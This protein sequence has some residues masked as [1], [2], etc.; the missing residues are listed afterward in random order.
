MIKKVKEAISEAG[1]R[2]Q[3]AIT[4]TGA[5]FLSGTIGTGAYKGLR[6]T[7]YLE[8]DGYEQQVRTHANT[9]EALLREQNITLD[10]HDTVE[11]SKATEITDGMEIE[12]QIARPVNITVDDD[13]QQVWST[14]D[15]VAELL[16]EQNITVTEHDLV[17]PAVDK[18]LEENM[19]IQIQKAFE[20][21]LNDGGADKQLWSTSA[22]VADFLKE[23]EIVVNDLDRVEPSQE[24]EIQSGETINVIR[25]EKVTDVVEEPIQYETTRKNDATLE[26]GQEQVVEAGENGV[27]KN[28]VE[29]TKENGKEVSRKRL[30]SEVAKE[31]T[32]RVIAVGTKQVVVEKTQPK[33]ASVR[34]SETAS[35]G[36]LGSIEGYTVVRKFT[37]ESTAYTPAESVNGGITAAGHNI[38]QN[39]NMRLIAVDPSVIP[40]GTRV[41]VE[42]YGIAIAGDTGGAIRGNKIDVLL[43]TVAEALQ[44]GRRNVT[45]KILK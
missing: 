3:W 45:I 15:T 17:E 24:A 16:K 40:L 20:V 18:A 9:V 1:A 21:T 30:S 35:N 22:T 26:K 11:P 23:N 28:T 4:L 27:R 12:V 2:R 7:V 13:K 8:V 10:T 44:W 6:D 41:W 29:I 38:K 31:S 43:P 37:V 34:Q 39:P 33:Q 32:N 36:N 25:V 42:G 5:L 14:V 19:D